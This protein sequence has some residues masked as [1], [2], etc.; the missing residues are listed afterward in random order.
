MS[1]FFNMKVAQLLSTAPFCW[2]QWWQWINKMRKKCQRKWKTVSQQWLLSQA[3]Y[4]LRRPNLR[5]DIE[6]P[7][8]SNIRHMAIGSAGIKPF[9]A[10]FSKMEEMNVWHSVAN[11]H[12]SDGFPLF[13][14]YKVNHNPRVFSWNSTLLLSF[15]NA[16][17]ADWSDPLFAPPPSA[18]QPTAAP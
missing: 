14:N 17:V 9:F 16:L 3:L 10:R 7:S 1:F 18:Q 12:A 5:T 2:W 8:K 13:F 6:Q 15:R 4:F 11:L